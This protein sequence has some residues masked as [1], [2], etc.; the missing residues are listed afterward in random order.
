[1]KVIISVPGKFHAFDLGRELM[2]R[3]CLEELI[4]AFPKRKAGEYGIPRDKIVS[5]MAPEAIFRVWRKLPPFIRRIY[6]PHYL[7]SSVYDGLAARNLRSA[8]VCVAW[9]GY[10]LKTLTEAKKRGMAVVLERGS[11]HIEYQTR[12]SKEEYETFG[13]NVRLAHPKIIE[14]ELREYETA[15]R[16]AVPSSFVKKTFIE[17]G[18]PEEKLIYVPYGVDLSVF[19]QAPKEDGVFRVVFAGG[20][21]LRKG[22]HYLLRAF[23]ELRLPNAELMLIGGMNDEIKPFFKKYEGSFTYMGRRPQAELYRHFSNGSVFVIASIE[24]GLAL[25]IPQAMACGLPVIA[26]TNTGAE[27]VV[28]DGTEGFIISIRD[29][30]ALKEKIMYLYEHPEERNRMSASARERVSSSFTWDDYGTKIVEEY[31][32]LL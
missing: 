14:K 23:A 29:V 25:V 18:I 9:A 21:S 31:N 12:I 11:S 10:A 1:M 22:V 13:A 20:M 17:K 5:L 8:D 27:D 19:R 30:E 7:V 4:T 16:I 15:D 24:E 28:R 26:T 3:N 6:N 32:H 2:K